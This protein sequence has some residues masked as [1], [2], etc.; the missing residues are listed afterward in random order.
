MAS[1]TFVL[2]P[3][4]TCFS[5]GFLDGLNLVGRQVFA[6]MANT[7]TAGGVANMAIKEL[8][9]AIAPEYALALTIQSA[10]YYGA[11]GVSEIFNLGLKTPSN[12]LSVSTYIPVDPAIS[13]RNLQMLRENVGCGW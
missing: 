3:N 7:A 11:S 1:G 13:A 5:S 4:K 12:P 8:I 6:S 9:S 10:A 2:T